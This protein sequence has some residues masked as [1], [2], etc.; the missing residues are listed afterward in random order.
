MGM[1][2]RLPWFARWT[3]LVEPLLAKAR[4]FPSASPKP[5]LGFRVL[6]MR[7]R[8]PWFARWAPLVEPLLAEG[9][10]YPAFQQVTK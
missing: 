7:S 6:G 3:P 1:R 8:L 9:A 10:P 5:H 4:A 2:S